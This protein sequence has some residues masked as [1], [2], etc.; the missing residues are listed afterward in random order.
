[1]A[2]KTKLRKACEIALH[3][4]M[5][6][7]PEESLLIVADWNQREIGLN[8]FEAGKEMTEEAFYIEMKPRGTNGQEPPE[9]VAE[10][11][12]SVD[13][14]VC[15]TTMSLTH[16]NARREA[17]RLGVRVATMPGIT[18][19]TLVRCLSAD[20]QTIVQ[21]TKK[22]ADVMKKATEMR[23]VTDQ[24]TDIT[25]S[26]KSRRILQSTGV[27]RNIGESGN[28]PSGEVYCA[29]KEGKTNGKIVFDGSFAGIGLLKTPIKVA[30]KAGYASKIT[31]KTEA[32]KLTTILEENGKEAFAIGEF[33]IGT[34]HKAILT[35]EILEDEK[36]LGTVHFAFG[37]NVTMGGTNNV[38]LHI[39]GIIT[40]P[41]VY[42]DDVMIMDKGKLL[43]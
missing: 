22:V 39:D 24:G 16:T 40:E 8:L 29:P 25:F 41:T 34:N 42:A 23:V 11:M 17:S 5:G 19:D 2:G 28:L 10:L 15:P 3:D 32:K 38:G 35:G 1:M 6:L 4:Y 36:I 18:E 31:G 20:Y 43:L 12:K 30:I 13:V 26:V 9:Q 37:N 14:V 21:T 27:M 7:V 33:G